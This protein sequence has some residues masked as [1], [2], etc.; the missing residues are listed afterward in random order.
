MTDYR[1]PTSVGHLPA[2]AIRWSRMC[3]TDVGHEEAA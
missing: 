3:P 2:A 1:C